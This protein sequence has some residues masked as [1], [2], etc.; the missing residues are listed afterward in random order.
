MNYNSHA[1]GQHCA[2]LLCF[3]YSLTQIWLER[4]GLLLLWWGQDSVV[5][6]VT[7]Y[8]L[9]DPGIESRWGQDFLHLSRP[10]LGPTQPPIQWYWVSF[11]GKQLGRGIEHPHPSNAGDKERVELYPYYPSGPSWP[12][13][14]WTLL[15]PWLFINWNSAVTTLMC[16]LSPKS[17]Q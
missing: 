4:N 15:L 5:S 14:G 7:C 8:R 17:F 1:A 10:A 9:E 11:L 13:L 12:V 2:L 3:L 6:T 16:C